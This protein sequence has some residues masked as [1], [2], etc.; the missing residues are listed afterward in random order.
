MSVKLQDNNGDL[1]WGCHAWWKPE[2]Y[3]L[4]SDEGLRNLM[5]PVELR[6]S[7]NHLYE[8]LSLDGDA[9]ENWQA[10]LDELNLTQV[11]EESN[12]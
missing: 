9:Q 1:F 10:A 12:V 7:L 8:R 5:V 11:N 2:D 3:V 6:E 4:F